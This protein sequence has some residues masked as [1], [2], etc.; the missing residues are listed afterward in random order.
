MNAILI[1]RR[2]GCRVPSCNSERCCTS[3]TG[4]GAE[5]CRLQSFF[6]I[7]RDALMWVFASFQNNRRSLIPDWWSL[8]TF[9]M[10]SMTI[11]CL[12][13]PLFNFPG[14]LFAVHCWHRSSLFIPASFP[15]VSGW[16]EPRY[17]ETLTQCWYA[18]TAV[19]AGRGR[20]PQGWLTETG[21]ENTDQSLNARLQREAHL[22]FMTCPRL[23][24]L[25]PCLCFPLISSVTST[26]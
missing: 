4:R 8:N 13:S 24:F 14:S 15:L 2:Q 20:E 3:S 1:K 9:K 12:G 11:Y 23:F 10:L 5:I 21:G 22:T 16:A 7:R 17:S 25:P 19:E 26:L 18:V 6:H